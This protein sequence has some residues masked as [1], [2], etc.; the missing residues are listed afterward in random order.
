MTH[1]NR[2]HS[3]RHPLPL[4]QRLTLS[5]TLPALLVAL[6]TG[7]LAAAL[8]VS[9]ASQHEIERAAGVIQG[10]LS[11]PQQ[12]SF[13]ES[14]A[15][16]R[17]S[18]SGTLSQEQLAVAL[19]S[20]TLA[21]ADLER[22][23][24]GEED[25]L[26]SLVAMRELVAGW[27]EAVQERGG[28][29]LPSLTDGM[30]KAARAIA[31]DAKARLTRSL[32]RGDRERLAALAVA[33]VALV[34]ALVLG[35]LLATRFGSRLFRAIRSIGQAASGIERGDLT[36]RATAFADDELGR[37][38]RTFN[39]M[40]A[41]LDE[42][43]REAERLHELSQLLQSATD[44]AEA[45][46]IFERLTPVLAP[47][48]AGALYLMS[49]SRD[50]LELRSRFGVSSDD[51]PLL[52]KTVPDDCWALRQ[53]HPYC[54]PD[55]DRKLVCEHLG[56]RDGRP[57]PYVCLPL[58]T[59]G[60]TLGLLHVSFSAEAVAEKAIEKRQHALEDIAAAVGLA[61]GNLALRE[62]LKAQAIRDP[63]TG[64]FNRRYL[65]ESLPREIE[66]CRRRGQTLTLIMADLDHFKRLNDAWGH[67]A[68]DL[69][70]QRFAEAARQHFRGEDILCRY[71]GEEF[72]F[73]LP[74]CAPRDA[75]ARAEA[76]LDAQRKS[77]V[78][79]GLD[80][81]GPVTASLG[82][83]HFP[84]LARDATA[85]LRMADTALYRAK[86]TGRDRLVVHS[87]EL[88]A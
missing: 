82:V 58:M 59:Q 39:L 38:A 29:N 77:L 64:L 47:G 17:S 45:I 36:Q 87:G 55:S 5:V 13:A 50:D 71:G 44:A 22:Q 80:A 34:A 51:L 66:R 9:A 56:G 69:A 12:W 3:G 86:Q 48:G 41:R 25:A 6:A 7:A 83:A 21:A 4:A 43:T 2:R 28:A 73:V 18:V 20:W 52:E 35:S 84:E 1:E 31:D 53:G 74:E 14:E 46:A 72:C 60:E 40:A 27:R 10:A 79:F 78:P 33:A 19:G 61:L 32:D 85:L 63:L 26:A 49:P 42:R 23:L 76:L 24:A 30:V 88:A 65:E 11:L 57:L 68:G 75:L 37:L 8:R 15:L 16:R 67:A 62:R 70:I 54:V 81:I